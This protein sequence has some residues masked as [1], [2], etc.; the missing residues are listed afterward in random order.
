MSFFIEFVQD[1]T[2]L[3]CGTGKGR[4]FAPIG[5]KAAPQ[6]KSLNSKE[7]VTG[8]FTVTAAGDLADVTVVYG[9]QRN[10]ARKKL[11][12]LPKDGISGEW[13]AEHSENGW[14]DRDVF[15]QILKNL[16]KW[17]T[18]NDVARPVILFVDG[19][20]SHYSLEICDFADEAGIKLWLLKPNSTQTLQPLDKVHYQILK[21]EISA[22]VSAWLAQNPGIL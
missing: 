10:F 14:M 12:K 18:D 8:S 5:Y 2:A 15:L 9:T 4:V 22:R 21:K 17:L 1:E 3:N 6:K 19:H 11:E 7:N 16:D 13:H 20:K